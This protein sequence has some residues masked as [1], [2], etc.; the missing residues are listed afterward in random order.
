MKSGKMVLMNLFAGKEWRLRHREWPCG[1]SRGGREGRNGE[2]SI[3]MYTLSGVSGWPVRSCSAAQ[4]PQSGTLWWPEGM[5]WGRGRT[6]GRG[7][8]CSCAV[9]ANTTLQKLKKKKKISWIN[10]EGKVLFL[11]YVTNSKKLDGFK[12]YEFILLQICSPDLQNQF[13]WFYN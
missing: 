2:S 13:R 9:K 5:G 8:V 11:T 1:H 12:Q 10:I 6:G 4:G 7:H 3:S